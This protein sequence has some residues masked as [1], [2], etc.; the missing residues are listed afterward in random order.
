MQDTLH[1]TEIKFMTARYQYRLQNADLYI[2]MIEDF[3]P[4]TMSCIRHTA[5]RSGQKQIGSMRL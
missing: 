5:L 1:P 2:I 4:E 3:S